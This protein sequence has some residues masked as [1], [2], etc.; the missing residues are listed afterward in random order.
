MGIK[1]LETLIDSLYSN[2][3]E[4]CIFTNKNLSSL[5]LVIDGTQLAYKLTSSLKTG[6]YGGNYDQIFEK[7]KQFLERLK[8]YIEVIIFDGSKESIAKAKKRLTDRIIR[9]GNIDTGF[10]KSQDQNESDKIKAHI[11]NLKEVP[12]L[13]TQMIIFKIVNE[14]GIKCFMSSGDSD[15]AIACYSSGCNILSKNFTVLSRNS[16][17][18]IYKLVGGYVSW[19]YALKMLENPDLINDSLSLPIYFVDKLM[20]YFELINFKSWLYFCLTC[21]DYDLG[22]PRNKIYFNYCKIDLN[23]IMGMLFYIGLNENELIKTN[24]VQIR[25]TYNR[26]MIDTIDKLIENF[27]FKYIGFNFENPIK[28]SLSNKTRLSDFSDEINEFDRIIF[29]ID[30]LKSNFYQCLVEDFTEESVFKPVQSNKLFN[31]VYLALSA[32]KPNSIVFEEFIRS[33]SPNNKNIFDTTEIWVN[34]NEIEFDGNKIFDCLVLKRN[35]SSS[36]NDFKSLFL[37]SISVWKQW[38]KE[39]KYVNQIEFNED[40]LTEAI[41]LNYLLIQLNKSMVLMNMKKQ[42]NL[43]YY[44][45]FK[46]VDL[47]DKLMINIANFYKKHSILNDESKFKYEFYIEHELRLIHRLNEFQCMY[48]TLGILNKFFDLKFQFLSPNEM[49]NCYFVCKYLFELSSS[50]MKKLISSSKVINLYLMDLKM[51]LKNFDE[52]LV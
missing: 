2:S 34:A 41:L 21:G 30:R 31:L 16:Y 48:Y 14:L 36:E 29:S 27:E 35:K 50:E 40:C 7:A 44:G 39:N 4:N 8:P 47:K 5:K 13:F 37:M 11:E 18:Y 51:M 6:H 43:E 24:Y 1:G 15:H 22:L 32:S 33:K 23:N 52:I 12:P 20:E 42:S 17:F 28:Y 46:S 10:S 25:R 26:D 38:L 9:V 3:N 49:L 19:K 45:I